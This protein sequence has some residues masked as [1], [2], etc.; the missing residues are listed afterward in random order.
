MSFQIHSSLTIVRAYVR[1]RESQYNKIE[2]PQLAN[3]F[4]AS[5]LSL[6]SFAK[7]K[8]IPKSTVERWI[9]TKPRENAGKPCVLSTEEEDLIA[10]ALIYLADC[11][12]PQNRSDIIAMIKNFMEA[13]KRPSPFKNGTPGKD[14]LLGFEKRHPELSKRSPE[15]LT[16]ARAKSMN[17]ES[18]NAFFDMFEEMTAKY[19]ITDAEQLWNCDETGLNADH[20]SKRVYAKKGSRDVYAQ[21]AGAG[22]T[23][24][25]VLFCGSASGQMMPPFILYKGKHLYN[26]WTRN[27]PAGSTYGVTDSGWMEGVAYE[28]WFINHFIPNVEKKKKPL[29]L[30]FD[31]HNSHLT[32][33]TTNAARENQIVLACI[34]P[35]SS[36]RIQPFDVGFFGPFKVSS[37]TPAQNHFARMTKSKNL[38]KAVFPAVLKEAWDKIQ[39]KWI[40]GGFAGVHHD[41]CK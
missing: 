19:G 5:N 38:S 10:K 24:Y 6:R 15:L 37:W 27:G 2:L 7:A 23:Y 1:K 33:K 29:V 31:G 40:I 25:S 12:M 30:M 9:K 18:V 17:P 8:G 22:K 41:F 36:H 39:P 3:E 11:N 34:P 16:L 35:H 4:R 20:R 26:T 21:S 28:G 13:T 32:Y 14:W